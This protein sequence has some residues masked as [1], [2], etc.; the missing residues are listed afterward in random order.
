M[1]TSLAWQNVI[2]DWRRTATAVAG[3]AFAILLVFMQLGFYT[4]ARTSSTMVY[5]L[6]RFDAIVLSPTYEHLLNAGLVPRTRLRQAAGVP[7]VAAVAPIYTTPATWK[8]EANGVGREL[9]LMGVVPQDRPFDDD[10]LNRNLARLNTPDAAVVDQA[11]KPLLGP[12]PVGTSSELNGRRLTIVAEYRRGTGLIA[13]GTIVVSDLTFARILG[14]PRLDSA[15]FGLVRVAAG[16]SVDRVVADLRSRLPGDVQ[17]WSRQQLLGHE[18]NYF[19][20]VKPVGMIF[21]S[22]L[23]VGLIVGGVILYQILAADVA[24]RRP[25]Y[26]TLKAVGYSPNYLSRVV[27]TQGLWFA[28]LGYVPALLL[29]FGL[30]DAVRH[31]A[32]IPMD[33]TWFHVGAVFLLTL[34]MCTLSGL[35]AM[36][37]IRHA[38]PAE[39][40]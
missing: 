39:L 7:G 36:R 4:S 27:V 14:V 38:D 13:D 31:L 34:G 29:S 25:Q 11:A 9:L 3:V 20:N 32:E 37:K 35:L 28:V 24:Q 8:N 40:F 30:Y 16:A 15:Q 17:V 23:M 10:D 33:L 19:L 12:H 2:H 21:T 18:Q 5:D 22:G 26:A 1:R 6:M